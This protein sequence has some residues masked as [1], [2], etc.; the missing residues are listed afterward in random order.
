VHATLPTTKPTSADCWANGYWLEHCEAF[1]VETSV[2]KLGYVTAVDPT[3][4]ELVVIGAH[5]AAKVP[6]ADI[7]LI[8]PPAE[9]VVVTP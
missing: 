3:N 8:D 7:E 5:G 4:H 9:R 6:F 2:G 1:S